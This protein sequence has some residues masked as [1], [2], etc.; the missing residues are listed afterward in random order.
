MPRSRQS[1]AEREL[2]EQ[3]R[4]DHEARERQARWKQQRWDD[5]QPLIRH[6][7]RFLCERCL[8]PSTGSAIAHEGS[9]VA[10]PVIDWD[11]PDN[12]VPCIVCGRWLCRRCG[13]YEVGV[14]WRCVDGCEGEA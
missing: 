4:R 6:Q 10:E 12:L 9:P 7:A 8:T 11:R 5:A 1:E 14:G 3:F 13:R 2:R